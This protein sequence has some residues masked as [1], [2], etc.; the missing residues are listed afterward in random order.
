MGDL[1]NYHAFSPDGL[2]FATTSRGNA[3]TIYDAITGAKLRTL[4][5]PDKKRDADSFGG[6]LAYSPDGRLLAAAGTAGESIELWDVSSGQC[7]HRLVTTQGGVTGITFVGVGDLL[8]T[9]GR[10]TTILVW[11]VGEVRRKLRLPA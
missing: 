11:D 6:P 2:T 8:A 1:G 9:G 10:D 7:L 5:E 4:R 3:I